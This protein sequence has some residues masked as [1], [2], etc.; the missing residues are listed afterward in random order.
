M[1]AKPEFLAAA[2][3][4]LSQMETAH[5]KVALLF[6]RLTQQ[7]QRII[8]L[9]TEIDLVEVD[10]DEA[11]EIILLP[12]LGRPGI[13]E[14]RVLAFLEEHGLDPRKGEHTQE[15]AVFLQRR[16]D[17]EAAVIAVMEEV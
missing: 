10:R 13:S 4:M 16:A 8:E 1:D 5:E 2:D 11:L 17:Y 12:L 3:K 7:Q 6:A 15:I 14:E 9:E